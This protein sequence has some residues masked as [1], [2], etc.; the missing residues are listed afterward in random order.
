[1]TEG[2]GPRSEVKGQGHRS[3]NLT[4]P[5]LDYNSSLNAQMAMK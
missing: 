1:M 5:F 2:Q 4:Y 3:Q